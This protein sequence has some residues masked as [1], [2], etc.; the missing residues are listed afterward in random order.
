MKNI[1]NIDLASATTVYTGIN[2]LFSILMAV[3]ILIIAGIFGGLNFITGFLSI[4]STLVFGTVVYSIFNGF[5]QAYIYNSLVKI[6]NP[7][8]IEIKDNKII[9]K[10]SVIRTAIIVSLVSLII[11]VILYLATIF[12]IPMLLSA[13]IQ[14]FMFSGQL[15]IA[16]LL[17]QIFTYYSDPMIIILLLLVIFISAFLS[18]AVCCYLYNVISPKVKQ[19]EVRLSTENGFISID[20]INPINVGIIFAVISL[21]VN[22]VEGIVIGLV[23]TQYIQIAVN[24]VIGF[25]GSFI[26]IALLAIFYNFLVKYT[27]TL[28][29]KLESQ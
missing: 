27:G 13:L 5:A 10:I 2:F 7:I 4:V 19:I 28:K 14:I 17:Y 1:T 9:E 29:F 23:T 18:T 16:M 22:I 26:V 21:I 8:A 15:A 6:F 20:Y 24:G 12:I 11:L 3:V 25:I